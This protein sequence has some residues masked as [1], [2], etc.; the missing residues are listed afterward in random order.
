MYKF[1]F[2]S[3]HVLVQCN[4]YAIISRNINFY[5]FSPGCQPGFFGQDCSK[6]CVDTCSGCNYV[7]GLC[8][9]GCTP[10]WIGYFCNKGIAH[11]INMTYVESTHKWNRKK[12]TGKKTTN[13]LLYTYISFISCS[14]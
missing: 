3:I 8:D 13:H 12:K 6:K 4:R 14:K 10:G 2:Q 5:S 9:F 1:I 11:Y 7:N